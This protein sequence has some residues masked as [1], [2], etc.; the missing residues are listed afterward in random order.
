[1]TALVPSYL[2]KIARAEKHLI[3]LHEAIEDYVATH[4]YAVRKGVEGKKQK[5]IHRLIFTTSPANTNI[6]II[7]A[8]VV[9]NL[10]SALDHLMACLVSNKE[11]ESVMFPVMFH[12][13][14]DDS[15]PEGEDEQRAKFR[16][17][18]K[19]DTKSVK[20]GALTILKALQPPNETRNADE[21]D[22]LQILNGLSNR[23]RHTKLPVIAPG[24]AQ[25]ELIVVGADGKTY[26]GVPEPDKPSDFVHDEARLKVPEDSVDV[27][28]KGT[29]LVA[30]RV[31]QEQ[32]RPRRDRFVHLP[33]FMDTL[34]PFLQARV[35]K[36]LIP[37]VRR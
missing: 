4:P 12:G 17:R 7:A 18:W 25:P 1:M 29:P 24:L 20:G 10:R 2:E 22:R 33:E 30:I 6:P 5:T 8:D 13:V 16:A 9:Y 19:S 14:W 28:I 34:I 36:P 37:Y 3:E 21:A 26:D 15:P 11:R 23:D 31:G 32:R 27:Q 35:I